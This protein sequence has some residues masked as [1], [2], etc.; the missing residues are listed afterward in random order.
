[1]LAIAPLVL[2]GV[3][4]RLAATYQDMLVSAPH[5]Q[6]RVLLY[7][8]M[9][10]DRAGRSTSCKLG[11][12]TLGNVPVLLTLSAEHEARLVALQQQLNG[13]IRAAVGYL[14]ATDPSGAAA[15]RLRLVDL[16]A[17][18]GGYRDGHT[19]N[20]GDA[21]RPKPW[22]TTVATGA[23]GPKPPA[24]RQGGLDQLQLAALSAFHPTAY[25]QQ[26]MAAALAATR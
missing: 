6:I 13:V 5:A 17:A 14:H 22:I 23:N 2:A 10:P 3:G 8:P 15:S 4:Q 20:C 9:F 1:M 24:T 26:M 25:G 18:W 19:V 21:D 12:T 11:S 7:P 16:E